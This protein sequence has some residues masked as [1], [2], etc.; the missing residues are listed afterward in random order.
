MYEELLDAW[1]REA[2]SVELQPLPG[3][4]YRRLNAF[5]RRLR[6]EER[7]ADRDSIQGKLLSKILEVSVK[8]TE[9]LCYLRLTKIVD[10][11]MRGVIE[12]DKLTE[13]EKPFVKEASRILGEYNR[14][15]R[16]IVEGRYTPS[17]AMFRTEGL[18]LVRFKSDTPSF[19]G[20]DLKVYGPFKAEDVAYIP[21]ENAAQLIKQD[22][23][24]EVEIID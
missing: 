17:E 23:A 1:R 21:E 14:M 12:W 18:K 4:F 24:V 8:L 9:D 3:D 16:R 7:L 15:V 10:A 11:S 2:N 13:D 19:V 20:V 5:M 22:I 6:E